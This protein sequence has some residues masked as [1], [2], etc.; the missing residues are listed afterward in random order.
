[1][2]PASPSH[3]SNDDSAEGGV[4]NSLVLVRR[5]QA[6]DDG[7]LNELF[8]RY[9][10]RVRSVVRM[11]LGHELRLSLDSGDILQETF[12]QATRAFPTFEP[13]DEASVINWL[14]KIAERQILAA[15]DRHGAKKR[16]RRREIPLAGL[17]TPT[18]DGATP[19]E[20]PDS[21]RDPAQRVSDE[22]EKER[23]EWAIHALAEEY[24]ELIIHRD[25]LKEDWDRVALETGRP[26]AAAAR[27][28]HAR[29]ML[30]LSKGLRH[31]P[32]ASGPPA[33]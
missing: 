20:V 21:T 4:E 5:A 23:L 14:A 12:I 33:S 27:M 28:M 6:G 10:E 30:E 31:P 26:S 7:A 24:R 13:R 15:A 11:R 17:A 22:E 18:T 2:P 16:D 29:A 19:L 32:P 9:Y 1:V 25:Y 3:A 8:E